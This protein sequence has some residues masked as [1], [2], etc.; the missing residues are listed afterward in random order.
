MKVNSLLFVFIVALFSAGCIGH[1]TKADTKINST[2]DKYSISFDSIKSKFESGDRIVINGWLILGPNSFF[3][4]VSIDKSLF[5]G[6]LVCKDSLKTKYKSWA[7]SRNVYEVQIPDM[8]LL[9]YG[10][11]LDI[12]ACE[13]LIPN[14]NIFYFLNGAPCDNYPNLI[15]RIKNHKVTNIQMLDA[16]A[17][18]RIWGPNY[19]KKGAI[20]VDINSKSYAQNMFRPF[21]STNIFSKIIKIDSAEYYS[22]KVNFKRFDKSTT[23]KKVNGLIT[24]STDSSVIRFR[25]NENDNNYMKYK[26]IGQNLKNNWVLIMAQDYNQNYFYLV[27][28]IS[29]KIDTLFDNP[30]IYD[31]KLLCGE[32][33]SSDGNPAFVEVWSTENGRLKCILKFQWEAYGLNIIDLYLRKYTFY[34]KNKDDKYLKLRIKINAA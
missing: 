9:P 15:Q 11:F 18:T 20:I 23:I 17:A 27:S 33:G 30:K 12:K 10:D 29:G 13:Y 19:S 6:D 8:D 22:K 31:D 26:V 1:S 28:Q 21:D 16:M 2:P 3:D 14:E 24:I 4:S 5:V 32:G 25:D 34:I 7:S